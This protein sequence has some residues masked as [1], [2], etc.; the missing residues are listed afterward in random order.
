M[1]FTRDQ[2]N[3]HLWNRQGFNRNNDVTLETFAASFSGIYGTSPT[4]YLSHLARIQNFDFDRLDQLLYRDRQ[5][6]RLRCMRSSV[7][8]APVQSLPTIFQ[9]TRA[10]NLPRLQK[11]VKRSGVS[12]S[13]YQA[14]AAQIETLLDNR[15]LT[16]ADIKKTLAS[17]NENANRVMNFIVAA[18]CGEGRLTR[19]NVRGGWTS[20]LFEYGLTGQW[21]PDV[22]LFSITPEA[23]TIDL[24]RMY[25][26]RYGPATAEDFYWWS[27]MRQSEVKPALD[28][29]ADEL[30]PIEIE[31]FKGDYLIL[32]RDADVLRF[33]QDAPPAGIRLL[34]IWDGYMVAYRDRARYVDARRYNYIYDK[35]GNATSTIL[36][37]GKAGGVWD[38]EQSKTALTVKALL[39]EPSD[40][41]TWSE[42]TQEVIRLEAATDASQATLIRCTSMPPLTLGG[43]NRFMSPL[44][45]VIGE[46][47]FSM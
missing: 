24:A 42:L 10:S 12:E 3:R 9:A 22:D 20:D 7:Y 1:T 13:D 18:M 17:K 14:L 11:L 28:A 2:I 23:A 43:Q 41:T 21:L 6:V 37:N 16:V 19:T 35:S 31:G 30:S 34:P 45:D 40:E 33:A 4:S 25:F 46:V 26:A 36:L 29:L 44:K 38:F 5:L 15:S 8:L 32:S 47:V 27:G 39:F